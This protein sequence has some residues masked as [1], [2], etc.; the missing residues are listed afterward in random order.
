MKSLFILILSAVMTYGQA[1][2]FN[3]TDQR[4][5]TAGNWSEISGSTNFSCSF[6]VKFDA[7][8]I[9]NGKR[10]IGQYAGSGL[11]MWIVDSITDGKIRLVVYMPN[12]NN[13]NSWTL[14]DP[15]L[16]NAIW[17]HLVCTFDG[18][19]PVDNKG[20]WYKDGISVDVIKANNQNVSAV[21]TNDP[22]VLNLGDL[23]AIAGG[24]FDGSLDDI[25]I[26]NITLSPVEVAKIALSKNR[27]DGVI[28]DLVGSWGGVNDRE[29]GEALAA[30]Q[31]LIDRSGKGNNIIT[32]NQPL[33]AETV[34]G[35]GT[36]RGY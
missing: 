24:E 2:E 8:P 21:N 29:P 33:A 12:G 4:G 5:A 10:L 31:P 28:R 16:T 11:G 35:S 15:I 36:P 6:W 20:K 3:G 7:A 19:L 1:I 30:G 18:T 17:T 25:R 32:E 9:V 26:Y 14:I 27:N 23:P 22:Q 34:V 13:F